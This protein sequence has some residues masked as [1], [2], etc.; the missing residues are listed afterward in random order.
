MLHAA[1]VLIFGNIFLSVVGILV[2][3]KIILKVRQNFAETEK[4][5]LSFSNLIE[6][7]HITGAVTNLGLRI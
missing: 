6:R 3:K 1:A 5:I 4:K 7:I 2:C